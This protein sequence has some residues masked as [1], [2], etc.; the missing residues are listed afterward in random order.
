MSLTAGLLGP[1]LHFHN[2]VHVWQPERGH[3]WRCFT[4]LL[5]RSREAAV[6]LVPI[7]VHVKLHTSQG[8]LRISSKQIQ[9]Q[10]FNMPSLR[11]A[12]ATGRMH[13]DERQQNLQLR[14]V[15]QTWKSSASVHDGVSAGGIPRAAPKPMR[16]G[17]APPVLGVPDGASLM[18][19]PCRRAIFATLAGWRAAA[20]AAASASAASRASSAAAADGPSG[21]RRAIACNSRVLGQQH[22]RLMENCTKSRTALR[23]VEHG[24]F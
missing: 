17:L 3:C 6:A 11:A 18:I 4:I 19:D 7:A 16:G 10:P 21:C 24:A 13:T 9:Q 1:G 15:V 5:I 12:L 20:A 2:R 14:V 23:Y 8:N 22:A